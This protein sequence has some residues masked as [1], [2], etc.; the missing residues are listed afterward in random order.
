MDIQPF[1]R[2]L[3][4]GADL[5]DA[6]RGQL[7][8]ALQKTALF[9]AG[10]DVSSQGEVPRNVHVVMAGWAC[11]YKLLEDGSRQIMAIFLPGDMC[12]LHVEIL[13]KMDHGIGVLTHAEVA[14]IKPSTI[15]TLTD[16]P[17]INLALSWATLAYEAR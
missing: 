9:K 16:N 15:N 14:Q 1:I 17:R 10:D 11:R 12:D 6:D 4:H 5:T 13:K 2:K 8:E 7:S 3:D